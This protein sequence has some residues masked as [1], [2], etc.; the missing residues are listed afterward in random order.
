MIPQSLS[1]QKLPVIWKI[2]ILSFGILLY[3]LF[4]VGIIHLGNLVKVKETELGERAMIMARTVAQLPEVKKWVELPQGAEQ[5]NPVVERIRIINDMDYIVVLNMDKE[6]MS[7]PLP[8]RIGSVFYGGDEGPAFAEHA[9]VSKAKGE[10]GNSI[11]AFAPIMNSELQQVGVVV[12]GVVLPSVYDIMLELQHD[13][14]LTVIL[15]LLFGLWGSWLLARNIKRQMFNL[16]PHEIARMLTERTATFDAIHEGVIAIDT[17]ERITVLNDAARRMLGIRDN[18]VGTPIRNVIPETRLPEVLDAREAIL[19]RELQIGDTVIVSNRIPIKLKGR[20]IGA[21]AIFQDRTEAARL[22]EEL[23]GVKEFV[24]A[25]RVQNHEHK[26]KLHTITGLI[27]LGEHKEALDYVYQA[28]EEQE[29]L[30][31]FIGRRIKDYHLSGLLLGKIT[32]GKELGIKVLVDPNSYLARFPRNLDHH[33]LVVVI[34][35]LVE[36]AFDALQHV[37]REEKQVYIS[38]EQDQD[39]LSILVEDNGCGMEEFAQRHMLERGYTTKG[40]EGR[41]IGLYLVE[42]VLEKGNGQL[43]VDSVP[44]GGSSLLIT[45]PM[46]HKEAI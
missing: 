42:K 19:N 43:R 40:G 25:L 37:E 38:L 30:I 2:T 9:Y 16:E 12:A 28:A 13:V 45:F 35:N 20:I 17:H 3:S 32:R 1:L 10:S 22:A 36:N 11:R 24:E 44:G 6:R 4:L 5:I 31:T 15:S 26:N 18:L 33:D 21:V 46:E 23:T 27:Q 7:H 39:I 34:G 8:E 14:Y 41:G 29:E